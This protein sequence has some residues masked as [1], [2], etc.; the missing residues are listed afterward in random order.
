[1]PVRK[2]SAHVAQP[3]QAGDTLTLKQ[4]SKQET[5]FHTASAGFAER[6]NATHPRYHEKL[7]LVSLSEVLCGQA[8]RA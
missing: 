6:M 2:R 3:F 5:I 8:L 1:M 7:D 4:H